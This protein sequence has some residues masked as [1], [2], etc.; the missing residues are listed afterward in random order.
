MRFLCLKFLMAL[1]CSYNK[2]KLLIMASR[3]SAHLSC[4]SIY[5]FTPHLVFFAAWGFLIF[6]TKI[7]HE[8]VSPDYHHQV[9]QQKHPQMHITLMQ[10]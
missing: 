10:H 2:I 1:H 5:H 9:H 6:I 3:S 7:E 8:Y 4:L